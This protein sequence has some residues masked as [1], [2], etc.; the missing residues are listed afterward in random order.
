MPN[1]PNPQRG[2]GTL[3]Q[4]A[5]GASLRSA[6]ETPSPSRDPQY[7]ATRL[8]RGPMPLRRT[9]VA[10][11]QSHHVFTP[12][13]LPAVTRPGVR[14]DLYARS[15]NGSGWDETKIG[16]GPLPCMSAR[17]SEAEAE[18]GAFSFAMPADHPRAALLDQSAAGAIPGS[19]YVRIYVGGEGYVFL[20]EVTH[21]EV[22]TAAD[23]RRTLVVNGW[24]SARELVRLKTGYGFTIV[25]LSMPAAVNAI[26][27]GTGW[28]A[29]NIATAAIVN[30]SLE[31]NGFS[32]FQ[33][34][35]KLA[36]VQGFLL[37]FNSTTRTVDMGPLGGNAEGVRFTA[38]E[39]PVSPRFRNSVTKVIPIAEAQ[40]VNDSEKVVN[41]V[42]IIGQTQGLDGDD[43]TMG[44]A[45][46][47]AP[48][49]RQMETAPDGRE[50]WYIQDAASVAAYGPFEENL[51]QRDIR[52]LGTTTPD[53]QRAANSLYGTAVTFLLENKDPLKT[54][55]IRPVGLRHLVDGADIAPV[56]GRYPVWYRGWRKERDG[57]RVWVEVDDDL[58]LLRRERAIEASG[59][60]T[61]SLGWSTTTRQM[62][63]DGQEVA[64]RLNELKSAVAARLPT[65][66]WGGNPPT[67]KLSPDGI[68]LVVQ[69]NEF[70][71]LA[72]SNTYQFTDAD[73][74]TVFARMLASY[75]S[76]TDLTQ[77]IDIV[78]AQ[79][80]AYK[81]IAVYDE[82]IGDVLSSLNLRQWGGT[83]FNANKQLF[84][85]TAREGGVSHVVGALKRVSSS[86]E[87][88][89]WAAYKD[90]ALQEISGMLKAQNT[91]PYLIPTS[92]AG[93]IVVSGSAGNYGSYSGIAAA[94]MSAPAA[95]TT[96][97]F[98]SNSGGMTMPGTVQAHD[99]LVAYVST[100]NSNGLNT[101]AGWTKLGSS[102]G[103]SVEGIYVFFKEASGNE[104]GTTVN[105]TS[106][107]AASC[108]AQ[109]YRIPAASWD[110]GS[111][112]SISTAAVAA[113][114]LNASSLTFGQS[115]PNLVIT[116]GV[117][118]DSTGSGAYTTT[119]PSGYSGFTETHNGT[120]STSPSCATAYRLV[121]GTSEDAGPFSGGIPSSS[122]AFSV[123]VKA[124][125]Y[126]A[127]AAYITGVDVAISGT[128]GYLIVRLATGA[129]GAESVLGT[130]KLNTADPTLEFP[131]IL[132]VAA[133]ARISA[134]IMTDAAS[135][136]HPVT[137]HM[138]NQADA[139]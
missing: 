123:S 103:A 5:Q 28:T 76:A 127:A 33:A 124:S 24:S 131:A 14:I 113:G 29:G 122:R 106:V 116:G 27:A 77:L 133:G 91:G 74:A 119:A 44:E 92:G 93:N 45:T 84:E 114:A 89:A 102:S 128:P 31:L 69:P 43:L 18:I 109:V 12:F 61:W 21:H 55:A 105:I 25:D 73:F 111:T 101:P 125:A 78:Y 138:L 99:C 65:I 23:G 108:T 126:V 87:K 9:R 34:L 42:S 41:K 95:P 51:I 47:D 139:A 94:Q 11:R 135:A 134:Q 75:V 81:S 4:V 16:G 54:Y 6:D 13:P 96:S 85:V 38:L 19:R 66:T 129:V 37:R 67:G 98:T 118:I 80:D 50:N 97:N 40:L 110:Y 100:Y 132:S 115:G 137:L 53:V 3:R 7:R 59:K 2:P 35:L 82:G 120:G 20:G 107:F 83:L 56:G 130:F 32:R 46:I 86:P 36:E 112:P 68:Q 22:S 10:A 8:P 58:Y 57:R 70:P 88:W 63:T 39:G 48:Y 49:V 90:G 1:R 117:T 52:I 71:V 17:Y 79:T 15:W 64:Q 121:T 136:N 30:Y 72:A 104:S 26:L 60:S 62:P